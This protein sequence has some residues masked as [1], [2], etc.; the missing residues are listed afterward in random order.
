MIY[1]FVYHY[2]STCNAIH[3]ERCMS[4][5]NAPLKKRSAEFR[6]MQELERLASRVA[7]REKY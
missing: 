4:F 7:R 1:Q 2:I 6:A 5:L 3:R